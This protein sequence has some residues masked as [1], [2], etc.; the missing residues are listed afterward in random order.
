MEEVPALLWKP[1][2]YCM[3]ILYRKSEREISPIQ[4]RKVRYLGVRRG[5][6]SRGSVNIEVS[7]NIDPLDSSLLHIPCVSKISCYF[8]LSPSLSILAY[9]VGTMRRNGY[10]FFSFLVYTHTRRRAKIFLYIYPLSLLQ[11]H[12]LYSRGRNL[13]LFISYRR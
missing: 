10:L 11:Q 6:Y 7:S 13:L 2:T 9:G 8:F 4:Y 3:A 12:F 5:C 1:G